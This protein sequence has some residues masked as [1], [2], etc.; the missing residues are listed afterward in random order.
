MRY[1]ARLVAKGFKHKFGVDF[2][3]TYA[4]VANMIFTRVVLSVVVMNGYVT[5]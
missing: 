4:P 5:E 3:E 1:K 2:L